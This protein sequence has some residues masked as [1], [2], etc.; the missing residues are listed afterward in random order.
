MIITIDGP[1]GSGKSTAARGLARRLS[2][3]YLDT[4]A[5]YRAVALALLRKFQTVEM[6]EPTRV[7]FLQSLRLESRPGQILLNE[8]DVS[9]EIRTPEVS[10]AASRV[11]TFL[12]V[13]RHLIERQR[14]AALG[15]NIVC[16][17][18]DQ[19]TVVFPDA[20]CKFYFAAD[21]DERAR[22]RL[23]ELEESGH[24]AEF[25]DVRDSI[26]RRDLQ[27]SSDET[28][29]HPAPDARWVDTTGKSPENVLDEMEAYVRQ[30][31]SSSKPL[32]TSSSTGP[33]AS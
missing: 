4:G 14:A 28:G 18:R 13:R 1:A 17:G 9:R 16:E 7:A 5:M 24:S 23:K 11:A 29:R 27:D 12:D 33:S 8:S 15:R 31:V 6:D 22:R 10:A 21:L 32:S 2:F 30:C 19:G 25:T 20:V 26:L 3:D